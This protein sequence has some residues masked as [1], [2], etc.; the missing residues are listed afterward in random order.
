LKNAAG[1]REVTHLAGSL[2]AVGSPDAARYA[3]LIFSALPF[4]TCQ[5]LLRCPEILSS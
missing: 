1:F 3:R 2:L 4:D 5:F